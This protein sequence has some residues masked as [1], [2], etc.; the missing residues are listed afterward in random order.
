MSTH[1]SKV[2]VK[3]VRRETDDC[4]SILFDIPADLQQTFS[5]LPGQHITIRTQINNEQV[6]RS[7]SLCSSPLHNEWR[8]AVKKME[9]GIFS[10][11]ANE[12]IKAGDT[13][14][15][16]PPLGS[17]VLQHSEET[18]RYVCFAAGSGITPILSII[19]TGL[20]KQPKSN[21]TLI[22]G[23]RTTQSIIFKEE[24]EALKNKYI[25]RFEVI[26]ILSREQTEA[27]VN[28][29]RIDAAKCEIIFTHLTSI[30]ADAFFICGPE[31]MIFAIRN[32]L[33]SK[34]V[35]AKKIHFEL[36]NTSTI[37]TAQKP[38]QSS[39]TTG[40]I[41]HVTVK[42]DGRSFQFD[43]PF[44][45][46]SILDAALTTGADLPYACKGGVCTTC[47]AK[48][49]QGKVE[50]DVNYGLEPEEVEAG[51]ILTCQ[52]HPLTENVVVD[53]DVK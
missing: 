7:Y 18:K 45:S 53:F 25:D 23:N 46:K 22:Y 29:G 33:V 32:W 51:Y 30:K 19:K 50:M 38:K 42:L 21:F 14:E 1:F 15:L 20:E 28:E 43:L 9:G 11:F 41:S 2:R 39:Q 26:Y 31:E 34:N 48:L 24:I 16:L 49:L 52:S 40:A 27:P 8:I 37:S 47:K 10:A 4:V 35:D 3:E 6:R 5:Y 12:Q 36:F 13:V 17:F 44:N